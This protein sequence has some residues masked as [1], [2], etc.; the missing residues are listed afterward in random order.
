MIT[1]LV[2]DEVEWLWKE[3]IVIYWSYYPDIGLQGVRKITKKM[4]PNSWYPS[5]YPERESNRPF[6]AYVFRKL[7]L[8]QPAPCRFVFIQEKL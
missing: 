8:S 4:K 1:L 5:W 3:A 6:S 7:P 2:N